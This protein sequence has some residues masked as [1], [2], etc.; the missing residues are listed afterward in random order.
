MTGLI[1]ALRERARLSM[2]L[3][4]TNRLLH[5]GVVSS[6]GIEKV[7]E[8][9]RGRM[10][11]AYK[12]AGQWALW[13]N[14]FD[15]FVKAVGGIRSEQTLFRLDL[16]PDVTLFCAFWPWASDPDRVS[17]RVGLQCRRPDVRD[18]LLS[19]VT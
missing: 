12:P 7:A 11:P 6:R 5:T 2:Q 17:V 9:V 3:D 16:N 8:V 19:Q 15:E 18:R 4:P 14:W 10:G 13:K 1:G